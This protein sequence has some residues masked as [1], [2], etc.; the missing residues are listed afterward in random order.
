MYKIKLKSEQKTYGY[1]KDKLSKINLNAL[2]VFAFF[3]SF[4][5]LL[6]IT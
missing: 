2:S 5:S 6:S 3:F 1:V 4:D